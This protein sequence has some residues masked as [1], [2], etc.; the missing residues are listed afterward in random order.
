VGERPKFF[1]VPPPTSLPV[2]SWGAGS[3][4]LHPN[5][6]S[7]ARRARRRRPPPPSRL[8]ACLANVTGA[9]PAPPEP[10]YPGCGWRGKLKAAG[11]TPGVRLPTPHDLRGVWI[12]GA[13]ACP[14]PARGW[15]W[16]MD[17]G[18]RVCALAGDHGGGGPALRLLVYS[19]PLTTAFSHQERK[20]N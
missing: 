14:P 3:A 12:V 13:P 8:R 5:K 2:P 20:K 16:G 7:G 1:V 18:P 17:G 15:G 4:L 9:R 6:R 19:R 11:C 10:P